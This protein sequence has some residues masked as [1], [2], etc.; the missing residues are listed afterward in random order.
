MSK[1]EEI[2]SEI[3]QLEKELLEE[4]QQKQDEYFYIIRGKRIE[5]EEETRRYHRTM[6]KTLGRYFAEAS[7]PHILTAP[8]IY[9]CLVPAVFMDLVATIYQAICFRVYDIPRVKRGDY[10]VIDRQHLQYLNL[11]ERMNCVY[12]GYFNGLIAYVQEIAARTEQ[13]WCPIKHARKLS[14][15]H[16]RYHKFLE[17]G[18]SADYQ[19]RLEQIRDDIRALR[20]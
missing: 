16:S 12:C 7:L 4:I 20:P 9:F 18:D 8:I 15:I 3:K 11:M 10:I 19:Q 2:L 14:T 1:L 13:Y 5:F 6:A 17:Y